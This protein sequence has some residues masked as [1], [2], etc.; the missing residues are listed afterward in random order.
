M[1]ENPANAGRADQR[2]LKTTKK[3]HTSDAFVVVKILI[4]T[5]NCCPAL[6]ELNTPRGKDH[7]TGCNFR[8]MTCEGMDHFCLVKH[9]NIPK[10]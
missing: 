2:P 5:M 7:P 6:K 8:G 1:V 10:P 4:M 3:F 9:L